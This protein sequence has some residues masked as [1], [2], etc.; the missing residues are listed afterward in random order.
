MLFLPLVLKLL[1]PH[2]KVTFLRLSLV[3]I[4]LLTSSAWSNEGKRKVVIVSA[5]YGS[6]HNSSAT[7]IEN[8]LK[9]M[10]PN[11][12][13]VTLYAENYV[14]FGLGKYST[15]K[16][17][18][19]YQK[20]PELYD[21]LFQLTTA[22]A[23]HKTSAGQ[24][25]NF[26]FNKDAL[27]LDLIKENPELVFSTHHISTSMLIRL[28]EDGKISL[29]NFK[30]GW[31]DTDFVHKPFFYLNSL[32]VEKTFLAHPAL[33]KTRIEKYKIP[34]DLQ[35]VTGLPIS[36]LVFEERSEEQKKDFIKNALHSPDFSGSPHEGTWVNG[37][38]IHTE[39]PSF[40]LDPEAMTITIASGKAGLGNYPVIFKS[41]VREA[42]RRNIKIQ[43][44]AICGEN[45]EN[46][47]KLTQ[48]YLEMAQRKE[49]E[50]VN[51]VVTHMMDNSKF[52]H[53]LGASKL[54][55]GKSGS[56]TPIEAAM[57]GV[58]S[59]LLDVLGGQ[60]HHTANVFMN[61]NLAIIIKTFEQYLIGYKAFQYLDNNS[62]MENLKQA[63]EI[64][65]K[66]YNMQPIADF[67]KQA[68]LEM[69]INGHVD[70]IENKTNYVKS[71]CSKILSANF[72]QLNLIKK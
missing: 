60:E 50:H 19:I 20:K 63:Q 14:R 25:P 70:L 62:A 22:T 47:S 59:I 24:I 16:F 36:P 54:F 17:I 1:T 66:S 10:D 68:L 7:A 8:Q 35:V 57:M 4:F 44:I 72:F 9:A 51:L 38:I 11:I 69:K 34:A 28:R 26:V 64:V 45:E 58:P 3:F 65:R 48:L 31:V 6:G 56:Q 43:V 61:E 30:I 55:I 40:E 33:M 13:V 15:Q 49:V 27:L 21:Y 39:N 42:A 29:K 67:A 5:S 41:L 52:I 18:E 23:E 53:Y 2:L 37:N 32:G 71:I 12:E 46:F